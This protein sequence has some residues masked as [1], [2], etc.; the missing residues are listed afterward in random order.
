MNSSDRIYNNEL[1]VCGTGQNYILPASTDGV[2]V[3]VIEPG[4]S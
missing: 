3:T 1:C 2:T 4:T